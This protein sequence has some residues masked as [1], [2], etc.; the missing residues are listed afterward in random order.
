MIIRGSFWLEQNA[1]WLSRHRNN[2]AAVHRRRKILKFLRECKIPVLKDVLDTLN[3]RSYFTV[4]QRIL[5]W[6]K[7]GV[8]FEWGPGLNTEMAREKMR[9]VFSVE[10]EKSWF[11]KY[12][13]S[14]NVI[15]SP[16]SEASFLSYPLEIKKIG[17]S[18]DIAFVDGRCRADCVQA[19][20]E[21]G[22]PVVIMH[23]SLDMDFM[24]AKDSAPPNGYENVYCHHGYH[25]YAF[26][27]EVV[28]LRTIILISDAS[29]LELYKN[30]FKDFY[31]RSGKT[32]EYLNKV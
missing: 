32:S 5:D 25:Y 7:G 3:F 15:H 17:K 21:K 10:H 12:K 1:L 27:V 16:I 31:I 19:C 29:D 28:D 2:R 23:D 8:Y 18:V 11:D 14:G 26:F 6:K 20:A 30:M 24:P 13:A 4:L 22:V 9:E